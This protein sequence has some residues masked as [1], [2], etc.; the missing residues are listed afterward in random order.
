MKKA[1]KER[2]KTSM[3]EKEKMQKQKPYAGKAGFF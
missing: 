1:V 2:N 3:T